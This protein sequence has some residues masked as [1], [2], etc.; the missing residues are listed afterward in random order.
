MNIVG[1]MIGHQVEML[2][3]IRRDYH[4]ETM[5]QPVRPRL[6]EPPD[7][8]EMLKAEI[9][10]FVHSIQEKAKAHGRFVYHVLII[11]I[12]IIIILLYSEKN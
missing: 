1:S 4:Q 11:I 10:F 12:I 5:C 6:P 2:A 3:E 9:N 7:H 8:R